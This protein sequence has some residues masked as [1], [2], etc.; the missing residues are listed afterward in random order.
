MRKKTAVSRLRN[1]ECFIDYYQSGNCL[2]K[3]QDTE[4]LNVSNLLLKFM[5]KIIILRFPGIE[6][7]VP[8]YLALAL[9]RIL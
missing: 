8:S 1:I 4:N 9:I 5:L 6:N 7:V 2:S 3:A